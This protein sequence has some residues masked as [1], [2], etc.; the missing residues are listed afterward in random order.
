MGKKNLIIIGLGLVIVVI[1]AGIAYQ[2][3]EYAKQ[4]NEQVNALKAEI[5]K[6]DVEL[7]RLTK[8]IKARQDELGMVKAD[9]DN[10][11]NALDEAMVQINNASQLNEKNVKVEAAEAIEATGVVEGVKPPVEV[12]ESV[13]A[14]KPVEKVELKV[15]K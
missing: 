12:L 4:A 8:E 3:Y 2:N 7:T 15:V 5:Q 13:E 11:K 6:K 1:F 9:L 10:T 14:V